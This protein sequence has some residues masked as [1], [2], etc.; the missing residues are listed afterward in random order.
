[1]TKTSTRYS[2]EVRERAVRHVLD[3]SW[4]GA[5]GIIIAAQLFTSQRNTLALLASVGGLV[6]ASWYVLDLA[7]IMYPDA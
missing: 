5:V 4:A 2:P 1:M 6:A 7:G 3:R